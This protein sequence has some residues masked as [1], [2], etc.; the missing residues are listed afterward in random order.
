[1]QPYLFKANLK[2]CER[3]REFN[4]GDSGASIN[5][6]CTAARMY[7]YD[8]CAKKGNYLRYEVTLLRAV[9]LLSVAKRLYKLQLQVVAKVLDS[10]CST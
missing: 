10:A 9:K 8:N 5:E 6:I 1:M 3:V 2:L 4:A 7:R